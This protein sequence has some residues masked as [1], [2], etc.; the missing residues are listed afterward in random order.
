[1][2]LLNVKKGKML[3]PQVHTIYGNNGVGKSTLAASFPASI[4]LDLEDGS[5]H[6]DVSRLESK[7]LKTVAS[8]RAILKELMSPKAEYKTVVID[9]IEALESV[10]YDDICKDSKV[11][12]IELAM[13]GY[14]KGI[15]R[16]REIM[17]EIMMDLQAL[18]EFGITSILVG[19]SHTKKHSDPNTNQEWDR[20]VMR[21]NDKLAAV[22]KDLSDN[23]LFA[24]FKVFT[25]KDNGKTKAVGDGQR[26]MYTQWRPSFDAKN[27][28]E[29]PLELPLSYD[30][31]VEACEKKPE[32]NVEELLS[33]ITELSK[34]LDPAIK[35]KMA[36][37]MAKHKTNPAKLREVKNRIIEL[38][39]KN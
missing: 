19:H 35:A 6:L 23:V 30:A 29:L 36:E 5:K 33:E 28:L 2:S 22:V 8:I 26:V 18:K 14:G 9:S 10:I 37:H 12:S 7:E 25:A 11:D 15:V 4:F 32:A 16:S 31:F 1:M 38:A 27:R 17:R 20:T 24:T 39:M 3:G 34:T 13:G 21:A